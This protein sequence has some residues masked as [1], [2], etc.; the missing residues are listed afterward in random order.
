MQPEDYLQSVKHVGALAV[1]I[2]STGSVYCVSILRCE[3]AVKFFRNLV[4]QKYA[5]RT[6]Q[7]GKREHS[8]RLTD[9]FDFM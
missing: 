5:K 7:N 4:E 6:R 2:S 9:F 8:F 1:C 3:I